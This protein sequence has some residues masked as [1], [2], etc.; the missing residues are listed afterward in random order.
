MIRKF[1]WL[2]VSCICFASTT[3]V[4][5]GLGEVELKSALNQPL[6]AKIDLLSAS[7]LNTDSIKTRLGSK[8]EFEK[9]GM[10]RPFFLTRINFITKVN[11][12]GSMTIT[13]TSKEPI[14]EPFLNFLVELDWPN[15]KLLR[16]Y[17]L[18]LDPPAFDDSSAYTQPQLAQPTKVINNR[19][20]NTQ[21]ATVASGSNYGPVS[22]SD[23]LWSIAK[24]VRQDSTQS[25][26]QVMMALFDANPEAFYNNNINSL[27]EG[28][29]LNIPGRNVISG[30]H[31]Q[32]SVTLV[33]NH[34][35]GWGEP[36][37]PQSKANNTSSN[38]KSTNQVKSTP[39]GGT[40]S[41]AK[42]KEQET[43]ANTGSS[44]QENNATNSAALNNLQSDLDASIE[45]TE[46]LRQENEQLRTNLTN[47]NDRLEK[48]ER[49]LE[50]KDQQLAA[51]QQIAREANQAEK[52]KANQESGTASS[53]FENITNDNIEA[54]VEDSTSNDGVSDTEQNLATNEETIENL[55]NEQ[56]ESDQ[57]GKDTETDKPKAAQP[58]TV[59]DTKSNPEKEQS[60]LDTIL[61]EPLYYIIPLSLILLILALLFIRQRTMRGSAFQE[62][63]VT[64]AVLDDD[65]KI[66]EDMDFSDIDDSFQHDDDDMDIHS[67][68]DES[69]PVAEA[70]IYIAYGKYDQA[71]T[72][73]RTS[74]DTDINNIDIHVKLLECLAESKDKESFEIHF[75][76]CSSLLAGNPAEETVQEMYSEA[77]P[78]E[79]LV[80]D[81]DVQ[82][83]LEDEFADL[84]KE[85]QAFEED[86]GQEES[87]ELD[88][89]SD[90]DDFNFADT[91]TDIPAIVEDTIVTETLDADSSSI[92]EEAEDLDDAITSLD[93]SNDH[94]DDFDLDFDTFDEETQKNTQ[95]I[96][97]SIEASDKEEYDFD[98]DDNFD[99][100]DNELDDILSI[101]DAEAAGDNMEDL[102]ELDDLDDLD[103]LPILGNL[104]D[105]EG[106][107]DK[108]NDEAETN[109]FDIDELE[110]LDEEDDTLSN[111]FDFEDVAELDVLDLEDNVSDATLEVDSAETIVRP[112]IETNESASD[113]SA[114]LSAEL[115]PE[116]SAEDFDADFD[117]DDSGDDFSVS[118]EDAVS[119]KLD[120]AR[121][122][123]DM[124][125]VDGAKDILEEVLKEATGDSL[126]E[127]KSLIDSIS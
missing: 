109:E 25:V 108:S 74:L 2:I 38:S 23:T 81:A 61:G 87:L 18:L 103:D 1:S 107:L 33:A 13:L 42:P 100:E 54:N 102:S 20:N 111:D 121:A 57:V 7:G 4:A 24:R 9:A 44:S 36:V 14:T 92:I 10:D 65:V 40:L 35:K 56:S 48:L 55:N 93:A 68:S 82:G 59:D 120:L 88:L 122:Y 60:L 27:K 63:L 77:W 16:E 117:F 85:L 83:S 58:V 37:K 114:D 118:T 89:G 66:D 62:K 76:S 31:Y 97:E 34:N 52:D 112:V 17:T 98:L 115:S 127:A 11:Q 106:S 123:I 29:V 104:S 15:G 75:A 125:D 95:S 41:L 53:P 99:L 113:L 12:D 47:I 116:I 3:A 67:D 22:S 70:D 101:D 21:N 69:D 28:A 110:A 80:G 94:D 105:S 79:S 91:A 45:A 19:N 96:Q 71:E 50:L 39:S 64:P 5:L 30:Y 84:E 119:T 26:H 51:V 8:E 90:D 43:S 32:S 73:L 49:L 124:G 86:E 72:L 46:V 126:G 6:E 78:G